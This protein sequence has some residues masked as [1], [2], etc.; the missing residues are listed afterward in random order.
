MRWP[1]V[2]RSKLD[3]LWRQVE[4]KPKRE[5]A[6][7]TQQEKMELQATWPTVMCRDCGWGHP[8]ACPRIRRIVTE[9]APNSVKT[10]VWYWP[11]DEWEPPLDAIS[12][13]AVWGTSVPIPP[14]QCEARNVDSSKRCELQVGHPGEHQLAAV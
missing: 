4:A 5:P 7:L 13:D 9:T 3:E 10:D 11:N 1:W 14:T 8:G 2:S 6:S 12:A